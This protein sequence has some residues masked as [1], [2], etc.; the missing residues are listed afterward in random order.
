[1][2][3]ARRGARGHLTTIATGLLAT[4]PAQPAATRELLRVLGLDVREAAAVLGVPERDLALLVAGQAHVAGAKGRWD[5]RSERAVG[6]W[7]EMAEKLVNA[8]EGRPRT[9]TPCR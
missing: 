5:A 3:R 6:A 8:C 4:D 2:V 1:M 9:Q 7:A